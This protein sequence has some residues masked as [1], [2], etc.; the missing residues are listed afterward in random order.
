MTVHI[1]SYLQSMQHSKAS[2]SPS[3]A[4]SGGFEI[5]WKYEDVTGPVAPGCMSTLRLASLE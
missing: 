3:G 5:Q 4:D 1:T 2:R